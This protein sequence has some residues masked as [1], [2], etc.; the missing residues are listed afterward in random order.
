[1]N[2]ISSTSIAPTASLA[3]FAPST[4]PTN[5][6]QDSFV[7]QYVDNVKHN[8]N[9]D[10]VGGTLLASGFHGF[11]GGILGAVGGA[12]VGSV[13]PAPIGPALA[14]TCQVAGAVGGFLY[15]LGRKDD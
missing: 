12:L 8:F 10:G 15:R 9:E 3:R 6:P 5:A 13:L 7:K 2:A 14:T 1:M 11:I 4:P